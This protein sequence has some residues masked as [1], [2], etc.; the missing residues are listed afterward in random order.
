VFTDNNSQPESFEAAIWVDDRTQTTPATVTIAPNSSA[1]LNP[2]IN[3]GVLPPGNHT[4]YV[5]VGQTSGPT[6]PSGKIGAS[7]N[8]VTVNCAGGT[9]PGG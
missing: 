6:P 9:S 5:Y 2:G 3:I 8:K 4:V 7:S 1:T